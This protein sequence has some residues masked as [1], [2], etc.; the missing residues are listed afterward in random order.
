MNE[1]ET[2]FGGIA[3]LRKRKFDAAQLAQDMEDLWG[4][5]CTVAEDGS[6]AAATGG[7]TAA[8]VYMR[9]HNADGIAEE[10]AQNNTLWDQAFKAAKKHK[11]YLWVQVNGKDPL[12]C[13]VLLVQFLAACCRQPLVSGICTAGT[14]FEPQF[15]L[16][17]SEMIGA[18]YLPLYNWLWFGLYEQD[19]KQCGYT[20]GMS[21][22]G[23]DE[24]EVL[25][26]DASEDDLRDYLF[27]L[28][29]YILEND[30]TLRGGEQIPLG[31]GKTRAVTR[32]DGEALSETTVKV[33]Y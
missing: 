26:A 14:L 11:A 1:Q 22:F 7:M 18:G 12:R 10:A 9:G 33:E 17:A 29:Y 27:D 23:K 20:L 16:D 21:A 32:G 13:G 31:D 25:G 19:E 28:A 6:V 30:I 15:Y 5:E 4:I 24:L 3:L 2:T 8:A